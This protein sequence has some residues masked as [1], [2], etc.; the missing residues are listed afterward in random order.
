M[1]PLQAGRPE[2]DDD[3]RLQPGKSR[4]PSGEDPGFQSL[5]IDLDGVE[6]LDALAG[7]EGVQ[8]G[9]LDRDPR[10]VVADP[11]GTGVIGPLDQGR[12]PFAVGQPEWERQDDVF[13][14]IPLDMAQQ[15][16]IC[17]RVRLEGIDTALAVK[18]G[19]EG[20][21][22]VTEIG[23]DVEEYAPGA[24]EPAQV[25]EVPRVLAPQPEEPRVLKV[26]RVEEPSQAVADDLDV[27][28]DGDPG[29]SPQAVVEPPFSR[30]VG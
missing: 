12:G 7:T 28:V 6:T 9:Q 30:M 29:H 25:V 24:G 8:G 15:T 16:G 2:L 26:G 18:R 3:R 10:Q 21:G 22:V 14:P 13:Q 11:R 27:L 23:A 19:G 1:G 5:H 20:Q 17:L 4:P